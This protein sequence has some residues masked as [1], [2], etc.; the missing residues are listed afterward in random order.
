[1]RGMTSNGISRSV[2][3]GFAIDREG[4]ADAAEQQL[5]FAPA[6]VEHVGGHLLEPARQ[7]AI[8]RA[9]AA[10]GSLHLIE[11]GNHL[12]PPARGHVT[13]NACG[14]TLVPF[15]SWAQATASPAH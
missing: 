7:L 11:G 10:V 15:P 9:H 5:G 3:V 2:R 8:G 6:I 13:S 4:D 12:G 1:M 14:A